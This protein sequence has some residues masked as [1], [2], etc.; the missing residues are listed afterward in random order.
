MF[1]C[2]MLC[3]CACAF[4]IKGGIEEE[5]WRHRK[6]MIGAVILITLMIQAFFL[7]CYH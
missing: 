4:E 3:V 7:Y 2:G 5:T 6:E 1:A